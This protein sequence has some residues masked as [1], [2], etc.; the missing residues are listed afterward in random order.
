M[1]SRVTLNH[2]WRQAGSCTG[3]WSESGKGKR[4]L[5]Y[6]WI[7]AP[8]ATLSLLLLRVWHWEHW[9]NQN[10]PLLK[11]ENHLQIFKYAY[12]LGIG[13]HTVEQNSPL[14]FPAAWVSGSQVGFPPY[15]Y[16][17]LQVCRNKVLLLLQPM[18]ST[19][20]HSWVPDWTHEHKGLDWHPD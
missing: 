3:P 14:T 8:S 2:L 6:L 19:W 16:T 17:T 7:T 5:V 1:D 13:L 15:L 9:Q 20:K 12:R 10:I 18:L 4:S 11:C